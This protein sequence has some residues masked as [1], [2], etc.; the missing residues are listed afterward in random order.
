MKKVLA[1]V[2]AVVILLAAAAFI[3]LPMFGMS[4]TDLKANMDVGTGMGAKLACSGRY[5]TGLDK[6]QIAE[7]LTSYTPATE[8]LTL[9]YDDANQQVEANLFGMSSTVARYREGIGCSLERGDT[10]VLDTLV[11]PQLAPTHGP[12]PQGEEVATIIPQLQTRIDEIVSR[13]N[14]AGLHTRGFL[15]V[16]DGAVVAESYAPGFTAATPLLGWS[17][18]KSLTSI[19]LGHLELLGK[20]SV[21]ENALFERWNKDDRRGITLENMLRMS[22][23]LDFSEV[24]APGSDATHMLF[25]ARSASGVAMASDLVYTPGSHFSYSSGTTNLLVRLLTERLGG[26]QAALDFLYNEIFAPLSMRHSVFEPDPSGLIVGSS[27]IYAST[28]DWAR[29]GLL[30]LEGGTLNGK[31]L[32]S[33]DWITR[34]QEPNTSNNDK[35]YGY[36]FWLNSGSGEL[37]WASLPADAYAMSGNRAQIVMVVPSRR[38]VIVRLGWT[39]GSYP[40]DRNLAEV[41]NLL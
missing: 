13:D 21:D 33:Q 36:H 27:Y 23:G 29:L 24:Y 7:D 19:M 41:L 14:A 5:I 3:I 39:S 37:R 38:A 40:F 32:L 2:A 4:A 35:R 17:M 18:A 31:R 12:W 10:S 11:A 30:M 16:H 15:V 20:L 34:A 28:R 8:T 22:S 25:T 1:G 6:Q 9:I 26:P